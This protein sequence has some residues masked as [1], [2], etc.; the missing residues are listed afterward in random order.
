ME[1]TK[2]LQKPYDGKQHVLEIKKWECN[3]HSNANEHAKKMNVT[4]CSA[5]MFLACSIVMINSM[6]AIGYL[7]SLYINGQKRMELV[8]S[9]SSAC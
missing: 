9:T 8:W 1:R 5:L 2:S 3:S 6:N 7:Y 4:Q